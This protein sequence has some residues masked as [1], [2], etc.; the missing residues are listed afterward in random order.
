[1]SGP[2]HQ[3]PAYV[4]HRRAYQ[5][6]GL[7]V[8]LL[9]LN[10]G[11]I[12]VVARGANRPRSPLKAQLQPFQ[13]LLVDWT[14][15]SDLKTLTQTETR[16]G[17][18]LARTEALYSGLYLNELLQRLL[19]VADPHPT[20]FAAYLQALESLAGAEALEPVLRRFEQA[21]ANALGYGFPWD[22]TSDTD[23]AI[24]PAGRYCYDPQEG[25]LARASE[26][27]RLRDLPGDALLAIAAGNLED[28][29]ARL[30]AKRVMR[31]LVDFLLQ[32]RPLNSRHLFMHLRGDAPGRESDQGE[33]HEL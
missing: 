23:A 7:M 19:P 12:T 15:R 33:S 26:H 30:T 17:P 5:E 14:G 21:L 4:L 3:E 24:E 28:P 31:V 2:E 1:M 20:V 27:T 10:H 22:R 18:R 29:D 11:R 8:D 25:L 16:S 9:T 13:P 32:G 6:H